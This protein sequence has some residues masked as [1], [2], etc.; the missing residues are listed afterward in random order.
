[1]KRVKMLALSLALIFTGAVA[2]QAQSVDEIVN[3]HLAA[4]GGADKLNS[5][6]SL[7]IEGN[8][9]IQGMEIPI[10]QWIIQNKALRLEMD[11]MGTSNIQVV[12]PTTGWMQMPVSNV[13][14]PTDMEP[15]QVKTAAKQLDISG[16][17]TNYAAKGS[18][19]ELKG[20]E[21][22]DGVDTY[23]LVMTDKDGKKQDLF[24]DAKTYYI[25]K[26]VM[27]AEQQGQE[28][29]IETLISDYR[30]GDDGFISAHA[31]EQPLTGMK[32]TFSKVNYNVDVDN[33]LFDKPTN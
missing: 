26:K 6:K 33:K 31:I 19:V 14:D 1:M 20:K 23:H 28:M 17:L 27:T 4:M 11:V 29:T 5:I 7:Y 3:R 10:K 2:S 21:T 32:M 25:V 13:P 9:E 12:K 15:E 16:D 30:K 18:K 24:L 8:M 22:L